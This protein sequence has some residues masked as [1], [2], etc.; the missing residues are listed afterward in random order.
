[1]AFDSPRSFSIEPVD[2]PGIIDEIPALAALAA[3]MPQGTELVVRGASEL[4][5]KESD[6]ITA[7]ARGLR[8]MGTVVEEFA[9]GFHLSA[10]PLHGAVVDAC[11]DHRLAMA[12]AIAAT[13]ASTPTTITGASAVDVSYPGFFDTLDRLT[14]GGDR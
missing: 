4:R 5:V 1:V 11:D 14:H 7:L 8:A 12:F 3:M 10:R 13:R 9:D 6:R 2:V